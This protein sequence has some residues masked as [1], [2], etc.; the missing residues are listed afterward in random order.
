M[1]YKVLLLL[2]LLIGCTTIEKPKTD[3]NKGWIVDKDGDRHFYKDE[4][5]LDEE[6]Y[7]LIHQQNEVVFVIKDLDSL[8][9]IK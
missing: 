7:C 6:I 4:V 2:G 3:Y 5:V 9:E 8:H 1:R